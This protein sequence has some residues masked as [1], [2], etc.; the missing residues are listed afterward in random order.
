VKDIRLQTQACRVQIS[1]VR[2]LSWLGSVLQANSQAVVHILLQFITVN[3]L[4]SWAA[5]CITSSYTKQPYILPAECVNVFHKTVI[6]ALLF[7]VPDELHVAFHVTSSLFCDVTHSIF[8]LTDVSGKP[9]GLIF[10][11][12]SVTASLEDRTDRLSRNVGT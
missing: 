4:K 10:K 7:I 2:R 6:T 11:F 1:T 8:T 5:I 12:K 3:P 9:V